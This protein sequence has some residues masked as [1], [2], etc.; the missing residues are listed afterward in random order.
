MPDIRTRLF[1]Q[2]RLA[3]TSLGGLFRNNPEIEG[4]SVITTDQVANELR[5]LNTVQTDLIA[6][7]REL[8]LLLRIA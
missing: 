3:H 6:Y 5:Q 1:T 7:Q 2:G 4:V 8:L